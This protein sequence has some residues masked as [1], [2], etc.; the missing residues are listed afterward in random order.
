M[1]GAASMS[2]CN[3]GYKEVNVHLIGNGQ[4]RHI[5]TKGK[6]VRSLKILWGLVQRSDGLWLLSEIRLFSDGMPT[7]TAGTLAA[8][9]PRRPG[10][11]SP[12]AAVLWQSNMN[13]EKGFFQEDSSL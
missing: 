13:P 5:C 3:K 4:L 6:K 11:W 2:M 8:T 7:I 10:A 1:V 12:E 9:L